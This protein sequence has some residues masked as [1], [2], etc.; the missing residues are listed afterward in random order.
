VTYSPEDE[1]DAY[2]DTDLPPIVDVKDGANADGIQY[3]A[4]AGK[5]KTLIRLVTQALVAR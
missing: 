1:A 2:N 4:Y 3:A 5:R